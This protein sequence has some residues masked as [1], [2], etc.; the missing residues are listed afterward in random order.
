M[1]YIVELIDTVIMNP[2]NEKIINSVKTEVNN[3]MKDLPIFKSQ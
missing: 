2:E 3:L 1:G